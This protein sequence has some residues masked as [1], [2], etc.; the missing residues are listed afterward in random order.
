MRG[1]AVDI[2]VVQGRDLWFG[3]RLFRIPPRDV[4]T[5]NGIT[6][7]P[8]T[9]LDLTGWTFRA[10]FAAPKANGTP[11]MV[12]DNTYFSKT[13]ALVGKEGQLWLIMW[14]P[15]V[16]TALVTA[17]GEYDVTGISPNGFKVEI[18]HGAYIF[19]PAAKES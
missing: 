16:K 9:P 19:Y 6:S 18:G 7:D 1:P 17:S 8:G 13:T 2:D 5:A 10:A 11:Q 15:A 4:V 3:Y 14:C 12:L